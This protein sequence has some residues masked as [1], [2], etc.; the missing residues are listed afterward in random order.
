MS[1]TVSVQITER[2][3]AT[4]IFAVLNRIPDEPGHPTH[5]W[6]TTELYNAAD[7]AKALNAVLPARVLAEVALRL[8]VPVAG[9][10]VTQ[11]LDAFPDDDVP[12]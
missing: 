6:T 10:D 12:L 9:D 4:H 7:I 11:A 1:E 3:Y 5:R 8:D 2:R